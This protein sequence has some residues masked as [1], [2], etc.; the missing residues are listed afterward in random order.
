K[1]V[2]MELIAAERSPAREVAELRNRILEF[3][4]QSDFDELLGILSSGAG[5]VIK[6]AA[7]S[8]VV[9]D[10]ARKGN[11]LASMTVARGAQALVRL[12]TEVWEK[13]KLEGGKITVGASGSVIRESEFY[14]SR[15]RDELLL[16]FDAVDWRL[17]D[18]PPIYGGL[19]MAG[20]VRD[21]GDLGSLDVA[22]V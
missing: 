15:V 10:A 5:G 7:L 11:S 21:S 2:L 18:Y 19:V 14:R 4:D 12:V 6:V 8:P 22:R 20:I 3:S 17:S 9:F 1:T 13:M 16:D